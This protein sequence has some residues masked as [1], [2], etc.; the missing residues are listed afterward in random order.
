MMLAEA[1]KSIEHVIS[2]EVD[3][4]DLLGRITGRRICRACGKGYHLTFSPPRVTGACDDCS[5]E[6]FQRDDDSEATMR[7]RLDVYEQQTAPLIRYYADESLLRTIR[8]TGTIEV[9]QGKILSA[10]GEP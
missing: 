6:L 7:K 3:R 2:I 1:G 9:I 5:G 10:L 8:G 4:E